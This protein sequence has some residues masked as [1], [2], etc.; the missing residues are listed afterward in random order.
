MLK[1][2]S[3]DKKLKLILYICIYAKYSQDCLA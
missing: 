3:L 2:I 1:G